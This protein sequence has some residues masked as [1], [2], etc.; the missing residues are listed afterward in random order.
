MDP[1]NPSLFSHLPPSPWFDLPTH[2]PFVLEGDSELIR[3][4]NEVSKNQY[5]YNLELH[6]E[7]F[8]GSLNAPIYLLALNPGLHS[9]DF[10]FHSKPECLR[11]MRL[12][13]LQSP[14]IDSLYYFNQ[15]FEG[16]PGAHWWKS[17]A[18]HIVKI[19]GEMIV[20]RSL[21]CV[22]LYPYH[23]VKFSR[24]PGLTS[25]V[26]YTADIVR[27]AIRSGKTIIVMR[28]W[29]RWT[30]LVPALSC[31][32]KVARVRNPLNPSLSPANLGDYFCMVDRILRAA[33]S[34]Q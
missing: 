3:R 8:V 19:Y 12:A 17:K 26:Q 1:Y 10:A 9:E 7:P 15:I 13:A 30:S 14:E 4:H 22:Q 20:A 28:S 31:Y 21:C 2:S 32:E 23:S 27:D 24:V 18:A 6:P 33:A 16:S 25:T 5:E 11:V 29:R 34:A